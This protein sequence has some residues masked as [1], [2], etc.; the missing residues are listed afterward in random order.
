MALVEN[1][2]VDVT[3]E[4]L[5]L[6][7]S[8]VYQ[9]PL[10]NWPL[11]G[12]LKIKQG[13][14]E[15]TSPLTLDYGN[16]PAA[17]IG[18]PG[19]RAHYEGENMAE[20]IFNCQYGEFN[21]QMLGDTVGATQRLHAYDYLG[22]ITLKGSAASYGLRVSKK[23]YVKLENIVSYGHTNGE[24]LRTDGV[25]TSELD[26]VYLQGNRIGWR[27]VNY[28]DVSELNAITVNRLTASQNTRWGILGDRWGAGTTINSLTCEGNGTQG[29][30]G[31]GGMQIAVNGTN[32]SCA[33][34]LNNPYFEANAGG[35]DLGIDNTGTRPVT[36]IINGGN[37]HRVSNTMFTVNNLSITS[38]GGGKVTVILNG[39]TF[40]SGGSYVPSSARPYWVTGANCEVIDI[41][42][43]F[44]EQTSKATS[45]SAG[46]IT[47][48]GRI[49]SDGSIDIAPGVSSVNVAATGVYD[50][51]FSQELAAL[52][53]GYVV[54]VTPILSGDAVCCDVQ[55]MSTTAFRVILRS[56]VNY[57]GIASG[58]AY[59]VT[60]LV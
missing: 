38:S 13:V 1:I 57:S 44:M 21:L 26:N 6:I 25:L 35:S 39:T 27:A 10:T 23:A 7:D 20:T 43:T 19:V 29:D 2:T 56:A 15:V 40:Q 49:S 9:D 54:Q 16:Y 12:R 52:S 33:L 51:V 4:V 8:T 30:T 24:G 36:V 17:F 32:G 31:T 11:G 18:S 22:G 28:D 45:V 48:S 37:F 41:G 55:Y 60:R 34:V 50:L 5:N 53:N 14:Y 42:C 59:T 3:D 47:R 58:F 46:S